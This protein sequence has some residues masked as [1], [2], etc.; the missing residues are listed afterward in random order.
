M[1]TTG[2]LWASRRAVCAGDSGEVLAALDDKS[3]CAM[4]ARVSMP[5]SLRDE[6]HA[7]HPI[8][9]PEDE[10]KCLRAQGRW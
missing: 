7:N 9:T 3:W 2:A 8:G 6:T 5:A 10:A 4:V 1:K